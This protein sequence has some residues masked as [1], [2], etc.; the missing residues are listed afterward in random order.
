MFV[1]LYFVD[2]KGSENARKSGHVFLCLNLSLFSLVFLFSVLVEDEH[3]FKF[4][5]YLDF[6]SV[7]YFVKIGKLICFFKMGC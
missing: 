4:M 1:F 7:F 3:K 2:K 6:N 5:Y